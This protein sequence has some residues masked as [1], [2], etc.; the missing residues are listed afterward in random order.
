MMIIVQQLD[1][2]WSTRGWSRGQ[3]AKSGPGATQPRTPDTDS[4]TIGYSGC[5]GG[6]PVISTLRTSWCVERLC[7][8]VRSAPAVKPQLYH[9][10]PSIQPKASARAVDV[11]STQPTALGSPF[12][13]RCNHLV[14]SRATPHRTKHINT[15][16]LHTSGVLYASCTCGGCFLNAAHGLWFPISPAM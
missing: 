13:L 15:S 11:F 7:T 1:L 12:R 8:G 4:D 2:T 10:H 16:H 14:G 3:S 9:L 6:T 5:P